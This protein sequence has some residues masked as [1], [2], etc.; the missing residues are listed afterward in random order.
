MILWSFIR[1]KAKRAEAVQPGEENAHEG[2]CQHVMM[3]GMMGGNEDE[4]LRLQSV[5]PTDMTRGNGHKLACKKFHL[6]IQKHLYHGMDKPWNRM[7]E[8]LW[9]VHPW[10]W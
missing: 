10:R 2:F 1:G 4:E 3:G 6:N 9:N 8:K 7:P 5:V